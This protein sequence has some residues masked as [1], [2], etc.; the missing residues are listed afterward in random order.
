MSTPDP[1]GGRK[2]M[3]SGVKL[4]LMG[5]G[6]A[7][8][9]YSCAP[10]IGGPAGL[11]AFPLLLGMSNPFYRGPVAPNCGPA[12]PG[13]PACAPNQSNSSTSNGGS[14]S[15]PG[16]RSTFSRT[17][18]HTTTPAIDNPLV[19]STPPVSPHPLGPTRPTRT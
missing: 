18:S 11:G 1:S 12:V 4:G 13:S 16:F 8:L 19:P 7:A 6:G 9:L 14:D 3:S 5:M 15:I 2:R 17:F 10:T